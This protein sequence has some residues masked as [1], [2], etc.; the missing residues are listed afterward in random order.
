MQNLFIA[1]P[2]HSQY[3]ALAAFKKETLVV[4]EQR[5]E[6]FN[7]RRDTLYNGLKELG[8]IIPNKPEGAFY[9]YADCSKF[10][11]DS[12]QFSLDLLEQAGVAVTPGIDFGKNQASRY[13]RF[14]YTTSLEKIEEGLRRIKTFIA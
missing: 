10:S 8:F 2:T 12:Y 4:L 13:I 14:A 7:V 3:A 1:A 5:R 6:E 11:S 9:I